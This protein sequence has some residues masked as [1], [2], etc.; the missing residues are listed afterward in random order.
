MT[1]SVPIPADFFKINPA[2]DEPSYNIGAVLGHPPVKGDVG[3]EVEVEGNKFPKSGGYQINQGD[4]K[5]IPSEWKFVHDGSLRGEDNAEYILKRPI[6][7]SQ[8]PS[9]VD[10]L[11]AMFESYGSK[12]DDSNRTSVHVHLNAQGWHLNR[13]T[14]FLAMYF[15]LEDM[16]T[17]WCGDHRVGNLFCLRSKDATSIV[18]QIKDF[19][20]SDGQVRPT[21]G[22]HYAG[23]NCHSLLKHG[24]IEIRT[25]RGVTEAETIKTWVEILQRIYELS[26]DYKDPRYV[27]EGFSGNGPLDYINTILGPYT[28]TVISG[29]GFSHDQ[30]MSSL[31]EGIRLAQDLCYCRDWSKFREGEVK[32]D[33]FG[34]SKKPTNS[35]M[36][37]LY[38]GLVSETYLQSISEPAV[39]H[40]ETEEEDYDDFE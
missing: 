1:K 5:F 27:V 38:N 39:F 19:I 2:K 34:R 6:K 33:P 18:S 22:M 35:T 26:A 9:A 36:I 15:S 30:V 12:L 8:V 17:H 14:S 25:L 31:Y 16:L 3:I 24:S 11:W 23:L 28:N 40:P 4:S 21:Q 10:K 13:M 7:F 32:V 37:Q 20:A 29:S